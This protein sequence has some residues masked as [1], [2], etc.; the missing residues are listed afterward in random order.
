MVDEAE[1][2]LRGLGMEQV[3]VRHHDLL[4]RIEVPPKDIARFCQ[5]EL[6]NRVVERFKHIGYRYVA[7][8]L[9]GYRS[10]S[11]NE[12][13]PPITLGTEHLQP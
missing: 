11:M 12:V 5:A 13:L 1:D 2:Y 9:Q 6:R 8:D 3:R 7:L 4:A 10:G